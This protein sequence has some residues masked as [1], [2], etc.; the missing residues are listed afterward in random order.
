MTFE[1][2]SKWRAELV[3]E[4]GVGGT[5]KTLKFWRKL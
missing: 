1:L 3:E 4:H 5:H 2:L